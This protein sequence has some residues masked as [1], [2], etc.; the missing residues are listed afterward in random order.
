M[1]VIPLWRSPH[2]LMHKLCS[3]GWWS[4]FWG[5]LRKSQSLF[6]TRYC[7][8]KV[9]WLHNTKYWLIH[10]L[11]CISCISS[12]SDD[13]WS[14]NKTLCNY[15]G[16]CVVTGGLL[17][18]L[19]LAVCSRYCLESLVAMSSLDGSQMIFVCFSCMYLIFRTA[20]LLM[21]NKKILEV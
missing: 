12:A 16:V 10:H 4:L 19:M 18:G 21:L 11:T 7:R 3:A 20:Q 14:L 13:C 15:D 6:M 5:D 1:A 9:T 17:L 8:K 2:L